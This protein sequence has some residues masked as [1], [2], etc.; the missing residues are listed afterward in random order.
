MTTA[1][2]SPVGDL[3][4]DWRKRRRL[5]QLDLALAAEVSQRH[6]SFIESGRSAPSR[7][8]VLRL[9]E[10]RETQDLPGEI[11]LYSYEPR[12]VAAI[13]APWNFP[14]A[15][16]TGMTTAA[17]VTG[18]CALMKPAEHMRTGTVSTG[19]SPTPE[20]MRWPR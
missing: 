18:N 13:I 14:L 2:L 3:L 15:I 10:P 8:M 6:L 7:D 1:T 9:A 17:L 16:L 11:N 5:S 19:L 4:R 12:G 20:P